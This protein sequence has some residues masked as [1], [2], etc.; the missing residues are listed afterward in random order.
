MFIDNIL[1]GTLTAW[2]AP[3]IPSQK[4]FYLYLISAFVIAIGSYVYF[5]YREETARPEGVSKG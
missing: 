5:S 2:M 4:A 3:L 1:G